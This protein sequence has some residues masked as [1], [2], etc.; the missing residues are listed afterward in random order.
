MA[1]RNAPS[2]ALIL[3]PE[4]ALR[5]G[6]IPRCVLLCAPSPLGEEAIAELAAAITEIGRAHV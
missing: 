4:A 2:P 5:P 1:A 3:H 6:E